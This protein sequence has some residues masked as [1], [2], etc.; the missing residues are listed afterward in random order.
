MAGAVGLTDAKIQGL[1]AP[2]T[3]RIEVADK[4]VSGL[5]IRVGTSGA[6]TFIVRKRIG[7]R[8]ANV[9]VGRF[10][11]QRFNLAD[12]RRKAR[13]L[14]N[15]IEGGGDPRSETRKKTGAGAGTVRALFEDYKK[16]KASKRSISEIERIFNKYVLPEIGDRLADSVSRADVTRL[17]DGV[18]TGGA[19]PTPVM[20]RAVAAQLSAFY[21]WAMPRLHRLEVNPC[22]DAGKPDKPKARERVLSNDELKSLWT[23]LDGEGLPWGPSVKLLILTGQRRDEV[24][25]ADRAEFDLKAQLWVIPGERA[26]NGKAHLV[27]LSAAAVELIEAVP[28]LDGSAKLFPSR[29]DPKRGASGFSKAL[30]RITA[31]IVQKLGPIDHFTLHDLRRTMATGLQ[32]LGVR[33]EVTEAVLNHVAGTRG[34]L[35]GVYQRHEFLDEKRH[36]LDAWAAEVERIANPTA[37][38]N[39][40]AING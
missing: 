16:A 32:R 13:T 29:S 28:E 21:S 35:V 17:I 3:G 15:D 12:A 5:R 4:V 38:G 19:K 1:K 2:G 39:V 11:D 30:A 34:G 36:A 33:L 25:S 40:V 26:K 10:H 31:Q 37:R 24:F 23:V 20:A 18:A 9:T 6:K 22:R 14:L 8:I 27:P 7:G